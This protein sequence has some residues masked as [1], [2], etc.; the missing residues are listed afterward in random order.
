MQLGV[1]SYSFAAS[2]RDARMSIL[3]VVDWVAQSDA[4]HLEIADAGLGHDLLT[5]P[6]LVADIAGRA[7]DKGVAL[8]NYVVGA[9]F[10]DD[11]L[12]GQVAT[13]RRHLEVAHALGITRFRHDV[14]AWAWRDADQAE[15]EAA[16]AR[17][18]PVCQELADHA[19][20]LGIETMVEN[21][22][23]CM[24]NSERIR[25][26]VHAVDRPNFKTLVDV[27]NFLCVDEL[28]VSAVRQNLPLASVVHLKDFYV[29]DRAPGK[30]W[31]TTLSGSAILGA[32]VGYG[33]L[34]IPALLALVASSGFDGP[35]S[36][37]FEGLGDDVLAVETG[38][39]TVRA[40]WAEVA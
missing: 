2:M 13:V 8:A 23:F 36:I 18:V 10:L 38:L 11:D 34:P 32:I 14:V 22:G 26:L 9:D 20:G 29:R 28:P 25:R 35:V 5:E 17:V 21:H 19:A 3:D 31:L 27:G 30:G 33:D 6:D 15:F 1:S 37:E 12:D 4:D 7:A 39:A 16:F 24:N 40:L